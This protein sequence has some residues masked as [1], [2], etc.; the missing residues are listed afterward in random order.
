M[1]AM[2]AARHILVRSEG[3]T[4]MEREQYGSLMLYKPV[5][6]GEFK[7]VK[8]VRCRVVDAP[9]RLKAPPDALLR[10]GEWDGA[11]EVVPRPGDRVW[12]HYLALEPDDTAS[13]TQ[14][15]RQRRLVWDGDE[16]FV[17]ASE[18]VLAVERDGR[19]IP[20]G[21]RL[22]VDVLRVQMRVGE[23]VVDVDSPCLCRVACVPPSVQVATA[24][25][26]LR[27]GMVVAVQPRTFMEIN[28]HGIGEDVRRQ[29]FVF[30]ENVL[31][32]VDDIEVGDD[33]KVII[34]QKRVL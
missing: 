32:V 27:E 11:R 31:G 30:V 5:L 23:A 21:G 10:R 12:V 33:D 1:S 3:G 29:A 9:P 16:L 22:L 26:P 25:G 13:L 18:H 28:M 15:L 6:T 24:D 2:R 17:V 8:N 20:L 7:D 34:N 4:F 14:G 19:V